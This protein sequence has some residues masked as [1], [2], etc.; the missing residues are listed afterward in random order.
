MRSIKPP[1]F[2]G[3]VALDPV[4]RQQTPARRDFRRSLGLGRDAM[5]RMLAS[6]ADAAEADAVAQ[7]GAD[8]VDLKDARRLALGRFSD[9]L[10]LR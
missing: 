7:L 10:E 9:V 1:N 8:V 4:Q 3:C 6:V 2:K 5:T